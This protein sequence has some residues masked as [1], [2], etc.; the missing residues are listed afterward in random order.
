M[1]CFSV[2]FDVV[3]VQIFWE[4]RNIFLVCN[5]YKV[6]VFWEDHKNWRNLHHQFATYYI[7]CQI[8]GEDFVKTKWKVTRNNFVVFS[9]RLTFMIFLSFAKISNE[10]TA[11]D[12]HNSEKQY[13]ENIQYRNN[14]CLNIE[15]D[16]IVHSINYRGGHCW[17]YFHSDAS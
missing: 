2:R 11:W 16:L 8:D 1:S 4:D 9:E 12:R 5:V 3:K 17:N 6:Q 14:M 15:F 10:F 7:K 13:R